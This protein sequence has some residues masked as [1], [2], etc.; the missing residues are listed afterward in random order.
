MRRWYGWIA[1]IVCA[2]I[3]QGCGGST[4]ETLPEEENNLSATAEPFFYQQW[5]VAC[6]ETFCRENAIDPDAG[7]HMPLEALSSNGGKGV[8]VA[9]IDDG[10]D[11]SHPE[12]ASAIKATY[13]AADGST[14][15]SY[16]TLSGY[17]GTAVTGL[18]ASRI[19]GKGIS[20]VAPRS[21]IVFLKYADEMSDSEA[22][23]MFRKAEAMGADII[24]CSWGTYHVSPAVKE[25][26]Q[27]MSV[28]GRGGKGIVFVFAAGNDD[29]D[30]G[31]DE[32]N[33]PEV[34]A[35]GASNAE[36]DR[37][38]Y[39]NHGENLDVLAPGG[40]RIGITT[41]DPVGIAGIAMENEDYLLATDPYGFIGTSASAPIV[42]GVIAQM[43]SVRPDLTRSEIESL[44]HRCADKIGSMPYEEGFNPYYGYGKLNASCLLSSLESES[45]NSGSY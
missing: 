17:H 10:L 15:V 12:I 25:T 43:L 26:I 34:I 38:W 18:I 16:Q 33:I 41:L 21:D 37:A 44:L 22:I 13:N 20:G 2:G 4:G 8:T 45:N 1:G 28:N 23:A 36:N 27:D 9:V 3:V 42:T 31:E 29:T 7:I 5:Y 30:M 11:V 35:V 24:N 40:Y 32:S 39:S 14:D 6:D 19:N